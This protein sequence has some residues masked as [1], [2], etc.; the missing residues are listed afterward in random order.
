MTFEAPAAL[1]KVTVARWPWQRKLQYRLMLAY[2]L[3]FVVVL[4]LLTLITQQIVYT[5]YIS[6]AEHDLEVKAFLAANALEDPLSGFAQEFEKWDEP[7]EY[8]AEDGESPEY[9][10]AS[11]EPT[12]QPEAE[13]D[14]IAVIE[15]TSG[16]IEQI[17]DGALIGEWIINGRPFF[18][19]IFTSFKQQRA[20]LALGRCVEVNYINSFNE[21]ILLEM[22]T[23]DDYTCDET[24]GEGISEIV[25]Y[26]EAL[27]V[28]GLLGGWTVNGTT[29]FATEKNLF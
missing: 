25:G 13:L 6:E 15:H 10:L 3:I 5:T 20:A 17:P 16:Y 26:V 22:R 23:Q 9:Q 4:A 11:V 2:G 29:Y 12:P 24:V 7:E 8:E 14:Q 28:G 19:T 21:F 27:P 1:Q 18:A